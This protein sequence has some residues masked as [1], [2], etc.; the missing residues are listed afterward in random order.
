MFL[1]KTG[2]LKWYS[3]MKK[4]SKNF[5]RFLTSKIAFESTILALFVKLSFIYRFKKKKSFEL[6][7]FRTHNLWNSITELILDYGHS[8]PTYLTHNMWEIQTWFTLLKMEHVSKIKILGLRMMVKSGLEKIFLK[9]LHAQRVFQT[10]WFT[11]WKWEFRSKNTNSVT[12]M[13][14]FAHGGISKKII[15]GFIIMY[16]KRNKK[17]KNFIHIPMF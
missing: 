13:T 9:I 10:Y 16:D 1:S 2:L 6:L 8:L 4:E 17:A 7:L 3:P 5:R 14:F 11:S 12:I 15:V